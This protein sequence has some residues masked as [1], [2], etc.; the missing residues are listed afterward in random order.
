[1]MADSR[2]T[3]TVAKMRQYSDLLPRDFDTVLKLKRG[4]VWLFGRVI[5]DGEPLY[6]VY[7]EDIPTAERLRVMAPQRIHQ[8]ATY[9]KDGM[10]FGWDFT[11]HG[12]ISRD[13]L[14]TAWSVT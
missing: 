9:S 11:F 8:A 3:P 14:E 2:V 1:M 10:E 7:T 5:E 12:L 4:E 6:R 13:I